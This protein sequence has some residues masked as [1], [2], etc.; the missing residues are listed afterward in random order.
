MSIQRASQPVVL[1]PVAGQAAVA[2]LATQAS[3][4]NLRVGSPVGAITP[5]A[6]LA[7]PCDG[8]TRRPAR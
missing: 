3:V 8:P 5:A 7:R 4:T 1:D 2:A 6:T